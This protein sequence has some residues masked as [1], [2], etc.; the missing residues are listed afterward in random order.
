MSLGLGGP[1]TGGIHSGSLSTGAP[2]I[3]TIS[4]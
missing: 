1:M 3:G 4:N 2:G